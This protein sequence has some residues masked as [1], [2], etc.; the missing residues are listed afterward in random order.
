MHV[1][2]YMHIHYM[3]LYK[4]SMHNY[5]KYVHILG[6]VNILIIIMMLMCRCFVALHWEWD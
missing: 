5:Y 2:I 1:N 3:T 4:D 6:Y